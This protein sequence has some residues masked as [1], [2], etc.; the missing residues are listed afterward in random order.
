MFSGGRESE[1]RDSEVKEVKRRKT[2]GKAE[3]E[4]AT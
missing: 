1:G 3:E 4:D 2:G